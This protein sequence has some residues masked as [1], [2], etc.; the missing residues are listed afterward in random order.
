MIACLPIVLGAG[1]GGADEEEEEEDEEEDEGCEGGLAL[2]GRTVSLY[3]L[4][5]CSMTPVAMMDANFAPT[6]PRN[7]SLP[8][9]V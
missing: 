7:V 3:S 4:M 2:A 6:S 9:L 1:G 8:R 5:W